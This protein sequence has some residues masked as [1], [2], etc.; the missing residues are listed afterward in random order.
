MW[1][2]NP[3]LEKNLLWSLGK[4]PAAAPPKAPGKVPGVTPAG[5]TPEMLRL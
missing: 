3:L 4:G 5:Q 2:R 1:R